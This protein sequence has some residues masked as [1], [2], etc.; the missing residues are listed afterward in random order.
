MSREQRQGPLAVI[1]LTKVFGR[2]ATELET[3]LLTETQLDSLM[4]ESIDEARRSVAEDD[5]PRP[6]VGAL[7]VDDKSGEVLVRSYRGERPGAHAEYTL[8][9]KA[10]EQGVDPRGKILFTT[11]EPCVQRGSG[12][13]PCVERVETANFERVYIGTLDPNPSITGY[14]EMKLVYGQDVGRYP[15]SLQKQLRE[16]NAGFFESFKHNHMVPSID[17]GA[18]MPSKHAVA[19]ARKGSDRNRLLQSTLDMIAACGEDVRVW[20]GDLSWL[21]EAYIPLL[22][23]AAAGCQFKFLTTP[24]DYDGEQKYWD[25]FA[26]ASAIGQVRKAASAGLLK[27]TVVGSEGAR[28]AVVIDQGSSSLL[29]E[30][31]DRGLLAVL[32]ERFEMEWDRSLE[33]SGISGEVEIVPIPREDLIRAL[34]GVS[35]YRH[36]EIEVQ[37]FD[38]TTARPMTR[39]LERFKLAR[40]RPLEGLVQLLGTEAAAIKGSPWPITPPVIEITPSGPVVMDGT[41]R[42][43]SAIQSGRPVLKAVVVK[44]V[45]EALPATPARDWDEV[46]PYLVKLPREQRYVDYKK[47]NFRPIRYALAQLAPPI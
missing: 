1:R 32:N 40:L 22:A 17:A 5:S 42:A 33:G 13:I 25:A 3:S 14:G 2:I 8:L 11:L 15:L 30:P 26:A 27:M 19:S 12:K 44:G 24:P 10:R 18:L 36:A 7:L 20:A 28:C 23:A 38:M 39:S 41:H 6:K 4:R 21:R 37:D 45:T 9:E 47:E 16:L 29:T 34:H 31:D 43:Y 46:S 35:Q